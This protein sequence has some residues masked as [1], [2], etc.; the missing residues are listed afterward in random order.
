[1]KALTFAMAFIAALPA[2]AH[3]HQISPAREQRGMNC[4]DHNERGRQFR[5]CE[6]REQSWLKGKRTNVQ[7]W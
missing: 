6:M 5:H 2:A 1:M 4:N 3:L 7:G